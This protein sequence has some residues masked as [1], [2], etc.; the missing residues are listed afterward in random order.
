[1]LN[2]FYR[3]NSQKSKITD[4]ET[5]DNVRNLTVKVMKDVVIL[6]LY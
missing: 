6:V 3:I 4:S 2:W 1:M 5:T